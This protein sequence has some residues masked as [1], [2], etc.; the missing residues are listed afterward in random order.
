MINDNPQGGFTV[1]ETLVA[2]A[3][4]SLVMIILALSLSSAA[5]Q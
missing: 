5:G 2:T 3:V 1:M 4:I